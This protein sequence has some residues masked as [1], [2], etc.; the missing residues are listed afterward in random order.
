M[1][2][3]A[4]L[5]EALGFRDNGGWLKA[6]SAPRGLILIS[7]PVDSGKSTF[8]DVNARYLSAEGHD[9]RIEDSSLNRSIGKS[10]LVGREFAARGLGLDRSMPT[11]R[12]VFMPFEM[13][14]RDDVH[15]A[16]ERARDH[17]VV[18]VVHAADI[19]QAVRFA[20]GHASGQLLAE[21]LLAVSSHGLEDVAVARP[22]GLTEFSRR[23]PLVVRTFFDGPESVSAALDA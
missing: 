15:W 12:L 14:G 3:N 2:A 8:W 5:F 4:R 7:G 19:A 10:D 22:S 13:R 9:V 18:T 23:R 20:A 1:S 21:R 16:I 6:L 11:G 17:L